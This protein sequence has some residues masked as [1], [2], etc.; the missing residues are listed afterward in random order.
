VLSRLKQ[1]NTEDNVT[2]TK[3]NQPINQQ[4][5]KQATQQA[6]NTTQQHNTTRRKTANTDSSLTLRFRVLSLLGS[7][8]F[9]FWSELR[10]KE[11]RGDQN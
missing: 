5:T 9:V 4:T 8:F 7:R 6:H 2:K 3:T 1:G 10:N 11:A